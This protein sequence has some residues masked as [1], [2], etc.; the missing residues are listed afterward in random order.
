MAWI[1]F[2]SI[3]E[4]FLGLGM[5]GN[6]GSQIVVCKSIKWPKS[7]REERENVRFVKDGKPESGFNGVS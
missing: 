5:I 3:D 1:D 6:H 7:G 2:Q 4:V